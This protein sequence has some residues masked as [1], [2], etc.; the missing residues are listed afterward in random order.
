MFCDTVNFSQERM[1][2]CLQGYKEELVNREKAYKLK[3]VFTK[4]VKDDQI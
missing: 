3:K 2:F 4:V 1:L